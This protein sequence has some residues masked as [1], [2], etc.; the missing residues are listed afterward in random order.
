[1]EHRLVTRSAQNGSAPKDL[2]S[3]PSR[4]PV[5]VHAHR[6]LEF[7]QKIE[8][9]QNAQESRFGGEKLLQAEVVCRQV[10]LQLLDALLHASALIVVAPDLLRRI[11]PMG[12]EDSEGV[13]GHVQQLPPQRGLPL[14]DFFSDYDEASGAI[15]TQSLQLKLT[16]R[17]DRIQGPP[18]PN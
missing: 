8:E 4:L 16:H 13:A 11:R 10:R 18:L 3:Q 2:R 9:H 17:V 5:I 12:H 7:R 15:P 14:A 6:T 1:M